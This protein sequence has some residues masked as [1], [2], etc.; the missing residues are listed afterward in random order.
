VEPLTYTRHARDYD[1]LTRAFAGVRRAIVEALPLSPGEVVLDVG[2]G[3]GLCFSMLLEKVGRHG[4]VVGIDASPQMVEV[5][6][7]R[8]AQQGWR[9]V[10]LVQSPIADAPIPVA[11][12]AALFCA[13]HD[14]LR[15][16]QALRRVVEALRPAAWVAAGGGKWAPAWMVALNVQVRALH[17]PYIDSFEGFDRPWSHLQQLLQDVHVDEMAWGTGYIVTGRVS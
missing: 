4:H 15:S 2:C 6:R 16:P 5:A 13:V 12:D 17:A 10:T 9:N 7:E 8:V 3:T 1:R 14:I 11:A